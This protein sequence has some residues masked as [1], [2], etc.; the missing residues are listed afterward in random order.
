MLQQCIIKI[1]Y[2]RL[3]IYILGSR[4]LVYIE[5]YVIFL[6]F[7]LLIISKLVGYEQKCE[8]CLIM[9]RLVDQLFKQT[10][11]REIIIVTCKKEFFT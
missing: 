3:Q 5:D 8:R 6:A 2:Y 7:I 4:Y 9:I 1:L 10:N 11:S